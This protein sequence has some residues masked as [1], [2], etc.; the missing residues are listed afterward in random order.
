M[1]WTCGPK[2]E[3]KRRVI[4]ATDTD[5]RSDLRTAFNEASE[6]LIKS[7]SPREATKIKLSI[8]ALASL[9][10][11]RWRRE[12]EIEI[13]RAELRGRLENAQKFSHRL[14]RCLRN[15][16]VV[17]ALNQSLLACADPDIRRA[18][19]A[20]IDDLH[21]LN[22]IQI[23]VKST[24]SALKL[25]GKAGRS[26]PYQR[27]QL[28]AKV[29]LSIYAR[30]LFVELGITQK[31]PTANNAKLGQF[32]D[33]IWTLATNAPDSVNDWSTPLKVAQ[34]TRL[35]GAGASTHVAARLEASDFA[36]KLTLRLKAAAGQGPYSR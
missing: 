20:V 25:T 27:V 9:I 35:A 31:T 34:A 23:A 4:L 15:K 8:L 30:Q 2:L 24:I 3:I 19:Q 32:L 26:G 33:S 18:T 36:R 28:S 12:C 13:G 16:D 21:I 7:R 5:T 22:D 14:S 11:R 6:I 29:I 10:R 17:E 1:S